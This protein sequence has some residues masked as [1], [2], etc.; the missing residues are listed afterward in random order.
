MGRFS[1]RRRGVV[2]AL[3]GALVCA[4]ALSTGTAA[5]AAAAA[6]PVKVMLITDVSSQSLGFANPEGPASLKAALKGVPGVTVESCDSKGT[7]ADGEACAKQAVNDGV[8]VVVA[9]FAQGI[10]DILNAAGIPIVG[11]SSTTDP[12]AFALSSAGALYAANGVALANSGCKKMG[13]LYLTGTD[14]LV[15]FVKKGAESAGAKEVA[16]AAIAANEPDLAPAISK[17]TGAGAKCVALSVIPSQVAQAVTAINQSGQKLT[18]AAVSAIV[19]PDVVKSLGDLANGIIIVDGQQNGADKTSAGIKK[20]TKQIKAVDSSAD[21]TEVGLIDYISG[22]IIAAALKADP[23][24]TTPAAITT[25][26]NG[27]QNVPVEGIVHP[28][29]MTP[30][31]N[32]DY[33]RFFNHFGIAYKIVKGVPTRQGTFFDLAPVLQKPTATTTTSKSKTK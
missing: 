33:T 16:R 2:G 4:G 29:S 12:N 19:T 18:M 21:I 6:A 11:E 9:G 17:L 7:S 27:L 13:I 28:I 31:T 5:G 20:V 25:A 22:R 3:V 8:A 30:L 32:P 26:L 1:L 10:T 23:T 15:D 14:A 24:A